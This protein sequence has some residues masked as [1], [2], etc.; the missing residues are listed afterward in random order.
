MPTPKMGET[1][2]LGGRTCT[3][4][5]R[6]ECRTLQYAFGRSNSGGAAALWQTPPESSWQ[7][8][9][10]RAFTRHIQR[11]PTLLVSD[12]E[13]S[14]AIVSLKPPLEDIALWDDAA[15]RRLPWIDVVDALLELA[16]TL[17]DIHDVGV[18]FDGLSRQHL[19]RDTRHARFVLAA[20][21]SLI[22]LDGDVELIWRDL[23]FFAELLYERAAQRAF[24]GVHKLAELLQDRGQLVQ[25]NLL[26]PGV[27]QILAGCVT[28]FGKMAYL[29]TQELIDGLRHLRLEVDEPL[30]LTVGTHSTMGGAISRRNNQD[31]CGHMLIDTVAGSRASTMGFFCVADGIGG[32]EDGERASSLAVG[33]AGEA[34]AR[35]WAHH[36]AQ[37][38]MGAPTL[39]ARGIA[40][41]V[42]QRLTVE[43]E[44][45]PALNRGGTTF[46]GMLFAHDRVGIGHAGDSR[47]GLV[48][49]GQ[50]TWLTEDHT[51]AHL[52]ERAGAPSSE[53]LEQRELHNRTL[54][55]F[56]STRMEIELERIGGFGSHVPHTLSLTEDRLHDLGLL[57]MRGDAFLLTSDG[58]HGV[59][60]EEE[61]VELVHAYDNPQSAADAIGR[62]ALHALAKDNLTVLVVYVR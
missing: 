40:K 13:S 1:V 31:S 39:F 15:W 24:P 30:R 44:F 17:Q 43:G 48:R 8:F 51:L 50:L 56:L 20:A 58:I 36:G 11:A 49:D 52:L 23:K 41:T 19:L 16:H 27:V 54:S 25:L 12:A 45:A 60:L 22:E 46:S 6:W 35:A 37:E 2:S 62:A 9:A 33:F 32:I 3:I 38:L 47:I 14:R 18:G 55:R 7:V 34:F 26:I 5:R 4:E 61:L 59:L 57:A 53:D 42:S 21:P 29:S 28:P 10:A